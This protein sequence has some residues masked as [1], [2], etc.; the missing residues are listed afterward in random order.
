[1]QVHVSVQIAHSIVRDISAVTKFKDRHWVA[2]AMLNS[3]SKQ[4]QECSYKACPCSVYV[5]VY[6]CEHMS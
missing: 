2:N 4:L 6:V 1:M 3:F 5:L